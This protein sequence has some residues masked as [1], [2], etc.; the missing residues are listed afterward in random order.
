MAH[1][2][3]LA[4]LLLLLLL[5]CSLLLP[6]KEDKDGSGGGRGSRGG[7]RSG[8]S[9][10]RIWAAISIC[11]G[12]N[13]QQFGKGSYPYHTAAFYASLLW[14]NQ[15][16]GEVGHPTPASKISLVS[17]VSDTHYSVGH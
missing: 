15:T 16:R 14:P 17:G 2:K 6:A 10:R 3:V 4:L 7:G 5:A 8:G 12:R 9:G 11:W 13:V 1:R